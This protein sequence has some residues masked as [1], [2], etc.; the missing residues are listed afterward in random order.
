M[1][2]L[3]TVNHNSPVY[4]VRAIG[5]HFYERSYRIDIGQGI[6]KFYGNFNNVMSVVGYYRNEIATLH[7][8]VSYC[9]PTVLFGCETWY[10]DRH[11]Y[12]WLNVL[13]NKLTHSGGF[14]GVAGVKT[15]HTSC[16]TVTHFLHH[17]LLINVKF[18][19]GRRR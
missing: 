3:S 2:F 19:F 17:T 5:R 16:I 6:C 8:I 4:S 15:S 18:S 9:L 7:L 11:D 13:W 1:F 10:L 12:H 14:S